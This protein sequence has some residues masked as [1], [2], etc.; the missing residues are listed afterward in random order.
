MAQLVSV[1]YLHSRYV[2][3]ACVCTY[4]IRIYFFPWKKKKKLLVIEY[5]VDISYVA[6]DLV[7]SLN[8]GIDPEWFKANNISHPTGH[9]MSM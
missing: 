2:F 1:W 7:P 3:Q 5:L 9:S 6:W 8:S 4:W